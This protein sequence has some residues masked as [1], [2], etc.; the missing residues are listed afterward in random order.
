M[1]NP[2]VPIF[3]DKIDYHPIYGNPGKINNPSIPLKL[4]FPTPPKHLININSEFKNHFVSTP[5]YQQAY[6]QNRLDYFHDEHIF[7]SPYWKRPIEGKHL[8][9][10][11]GIRISSRDKKRVPQNLSLSPLYKQK[12]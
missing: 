11:N 4:N 7:L 10:L 2:S 3:F 12:R 9:Y 5:L 1:I 6:K 8:N